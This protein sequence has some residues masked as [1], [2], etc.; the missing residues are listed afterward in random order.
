MLSVKYRYFFFYQ[1]PFSSKYASV[2]KCILSLLFVF[3]F[4]ITVLI[5]LFYSSKSK[6]EPFKYYK[7]EK[8]EDLKNK[9]KK[10]SLKKNR[11]SVSSLGLLDTTILDKDDNT[12]IQNAKNIIKIDNIYNQR[13]NTEI[14]TEARQILLETPL[15]EKKIYDSVEW[16]AATK[17]EKSIETFQ[18]SKP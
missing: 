2:F 13:M 11:T 9:K 8:E 10:E 14:D 17:G 7:E 12:I 1:W 4:S 18:K 16:N 5:S 6:K 3:Q 15:I